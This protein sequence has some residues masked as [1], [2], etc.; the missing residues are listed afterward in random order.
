MN[1]LSAILW[2]AMISEA[3][4]M[5]QKPDFSALFQA[6]PYPYLLI[7]T[8]F[9][10]VGANPSYLRSTG[11]TAE[12]IVEK[13]IFDAFPVNPAD[14]A[15]TN[16]NEVRSSI[17]LAISTGQPHT[18][19]LLRYAVPR[20]TAEGTVFDERYWSAVHTPV[21]DQQGK[22]VLVAQNAIDVTELYRFDETSKLYFLKQELNAVPGVIDISRPQMHVAMTRIL[23][24]ERQQLRTLFNQAPGFIAVLIGRSHVFEL[25]NEAYYQLV[26]HREIIGKPV[27]EALPEVAGQGYEEFLAHVFETGEPVVMHKKK[28]VVQREP[29]GPLLERYVDLLYQ[30][31]FSDDGRVTGIF[32]Q[33]NDVTDA[34]AAN[35]ALAE[36]VQQLEQARAQQAFQLEVSDRL[37]QLFDPSDIFVTTCQLI[38]RQFGASRVLW[39]DYDAEKKLVNYH[40]NYTNGSASPLNGAYPT[41]IFGAANFASLEDGTTWICDDLS[42]DPRTSGSDTW[43]TFEA[44]NIYSAVV[45]PLT[46]NQAFIACLFVN[47][48]QA[49]HWTGEEV[50]LIRD[51]AERAWSALE[52]VRAEAALKDADR[53]KDQ[54]LAMLAHELRNPLAPISAAAQLLKVADLHPKHLHS[55]SDIIARQVS[56]MT[57]L[58]DDLLDVSRVTTGLVVL[59]RTAVDV[60]EVVAD[61]VEQVRPLIEARKH[62]FSVQ[63]TFESVLVQGD[64]NRLV[65]VVANLINN[66]AKYTQ[67]EGTILMRVDVR[68]DL[69]A[70]SVSDNGIGISTELLPKVFELF[71]QGERTPDRSQGGLGL[72][73]ALV[74]SLVELHGGSVSVDSKGANAGSTFTVRLPRLIRDKEAAVPADETEAV[75]NTINELRVMVVDDNADAADMLGLFLE[76]K[77]YHVAIEHDA[78]AALER[79][80]HE[81]FDAFLLDIGLPGMSGNELARRLRALPQAASTLMVAVTGYGSHIDRDS[82]LAAGFDE[83]IVKPADPMKVIALLSQ[84]QKS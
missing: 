37:R 52:R 35:Q 22:V 15:S 51:V 16:L 11:R 10:I 36:K 13:H 2:V 56:H 40:S 46:R 28:V 50:D 47:T 7:D 78:H 61:A 59:D 18:S 41:A 72:G 57:A 66:A 68:D 3:G 67:E 23:N 5:P 70:I 14:P 26:G 83:H 6:S 69:V 77:G 80:K 71:A 25:V 27:W 76:T 4:Y 84:V 75:Q 53:R 79:A 32:A 19:A 17:E 64:Y 39:G 24:A 20:Q 29:D 34:H 54:F 48:S 33:G 55:T 62:D 8:D 30:P 21:F 38:G 49:R 44:L 81:S 43:P 73:L 63:M 82:S 12:D 45:V 60:K 42:Q 31:I 74:K 65:Q 9:I 58:V 1:Q